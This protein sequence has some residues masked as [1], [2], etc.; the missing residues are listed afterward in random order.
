MGRALAPTVDAEMRAAEPA[1]L[2]W[3]LLSLRGTFDGSRTSPS[4]AT[5]YGV[6]VT[7]RGR[8]RVTLFARQLNEHPRVWIKKQSFA[9][10]SL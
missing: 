3:L 10:F 9:E 8:W 1:P 2:I 4:L 6:P 5:K 7:K